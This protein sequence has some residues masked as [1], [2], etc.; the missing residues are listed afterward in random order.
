M[1]VN[2]TAGVG[3]Q[4]SARFLTLPRIA[5]YCFLV[6]FTV[7]LSLTMPRPALASATTLSVDN[8]NPNAGY[9]V[10]SWQGGKGPFELSESTPD[11][12]ERVL[13]QGPDTA[14]LVSGKATGAHTYRVRTVGDDWSAPLAVEVQHHPLIR[15]FA[16]FFTGALVF[17]A[18]L[19]LVWQGARET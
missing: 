13:Y 11:G 7:A 19:A 4:G 14:R 8:A 6:I 17:F 16:F 10:L 9:F 12:S 1:L 3:R 5:E 15:A 2:T 18:T